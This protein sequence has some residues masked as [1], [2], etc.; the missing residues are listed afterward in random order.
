MLAYPNG[1]GEW[2]RTPLIEKELKPLA[3]IFLTIL[4]FTLVNAISFFVYRLRFT[5]S[6]KLEENRSL[7]YSEQKVENETKTGELSSVTAQGLKS[8]R[9]GTLSLCAIYATCFVILSCYFI[10]VIG[11]YADCQVSQIV[12]H[13]T[14]ACN[15]ISCSCIPLIRFAFTAIIASGARLKR[16]PT[17]YSPFGGS[18]SF[19]LSLYTSIKTAFEIT[20][21]SLATCVKPISLS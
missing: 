20:S 7:L 2:T 12:L 9:W 17:L 11:F 16:M 8:S 19:G 21:A 10:L 4:V 15:D 14:T 13:Y 1:P 18:L 3:L 5:Q 6:Q